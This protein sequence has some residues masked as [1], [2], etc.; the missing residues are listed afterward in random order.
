MNRRAPVRTIILDFDGVLLESNDDKMQ[1]FEDLFALHSNFSDAMRAFHLANYSRPRMIKFE[2]YVYHIMDRPGDEN[3]VQEM[4]GQFSKMVTAR[5]IACR[6]V[7]GAA[8]FL[9]EF[10][11]KVPLYISSTTPQEELIHII[12]ARGMGH[13]FRDVFGDPPV[14]KADAIQDVLQREQL[15]PSAVVF[16]GDAVS[17]YRVATEAKLQF[18][19]RNSGLPFDGVGTKLYNDLAEIGDV[20]RTWIKE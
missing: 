11:K 19:G 17:D 10:S 7:P 16:V 9:E 14:K 2:H 5:V 1:A 8:E 3:A 12:E 20:L 6:Q 18:L 4:A 15:P 13:Y